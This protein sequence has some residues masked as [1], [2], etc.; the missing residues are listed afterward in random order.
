M[1]LYLGTDCKEEMGAT[2]TARAPKIPLLRP[3]TAAQD[4]GDTPC[5]VSIVHLRERLHC[6]RLSVNLTLKGR[7][8]G[9][10]RRTQGRR[11]VYLRFAS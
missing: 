11:C 10:G 1:F 6:K 7:V 9:A 5:T 8:Y 2:A 3:P 4:T